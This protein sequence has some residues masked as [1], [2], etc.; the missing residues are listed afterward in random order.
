M[1][2]A[3]VLLLLGPLLAAGCISSNPD[4]DPPTS[5]DVPPALAVE[6]GNYTIN[7]TITGAVA[8]AGNNRS[9]QNTYD[10][11]EFEAPANATYLEIELTWTGTPSPPEQMKLTLQRRGAQYRYYMVDQVVGSSP[12]T[13]NLTEPGMPGTFFRTFTYVAGE[14]AFSE[15]KSQAKVAFWNRDPND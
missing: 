13:L 6:V 8:A 1:A 9:Y 2:R 10:R 3:A 15:I 7:G 4:Y 12:L 11:Y 14:G 5:S